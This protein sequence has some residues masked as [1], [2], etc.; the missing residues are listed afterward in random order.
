VCEEVFLLLVRKK[1]TN[2]K[3]EQYTNI[4]FLAKLKKIATK[5]AL[6]GPAD[7]SESSRD[8]ISI[9]PSTTAE[10]ASVEIRATEAADFLNSIYFQRRQNYN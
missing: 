8:T 7:S 6:E 9:Q 10:Q 4:K 3:I 5:I 2:T 1:I